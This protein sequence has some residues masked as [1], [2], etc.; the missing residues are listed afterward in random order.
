M[1][2]PSIIMSWVVVLNAII[3]PVA[4]LVRYIQG[5]RRKQTELLDIKSEILQRD[6]DRQEVIT[7]SAMDVL[8]EMR[9]MRKDDLKEIGLL[10]IT[11]KHQS[12]ALLECLEAA[13]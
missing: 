13:A 8:R 4:G 9:E 11:L 3:L 5:R 10:K 6:V 1:N 12:A 2:D 7:G